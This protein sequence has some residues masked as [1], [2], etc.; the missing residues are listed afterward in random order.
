M[1]RRV[2]KTVAALVIASFGACAQSQTFEVASV[3]QIE[4]NSMFPNRAPQRTG[5]RIVWVTNRVLLPRYAFH[6]QDWQMVGLEPDDADY[7]MEAKSDATAADEQIRVMFQTL[8]TERF[9]LAVHRET[10]ELSG[11]NLI[12]GK[13]GP[14]IKP[15][16]EGEKPAAMPEWF[17]GRTLA[18]A[19]SMEGTIVQSVEGRG[20]LALTGRRVTMGQLAEALQ[21]PLKTVVW[22]KTGMSGKYYFALL[23][24]RDDAHVGDRP[25][26]E[27]ANRELDPLSAYPDGTD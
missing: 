8:L 23:F 22:D 18:M 11:Y 1:M 14:K 13:K 3:K 2:M 5:D 12:G 27:I 24:A 6:L 20:Q 7:K 9:K 15:V 19:K 25:H 26:G 4:T 16:A 21:D 10:R 17:R